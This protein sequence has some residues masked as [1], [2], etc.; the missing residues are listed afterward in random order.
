MANNFTQLKDGSGAIT[1]PMLNERMRSKMFTPGYQG[2]PRYRCFGRVA[3]NTVGTSSGAILFV[4]NIQSI[5]AVDKGAYII[6]TNNRNSTFEMLVTQL[7]PVYGTPPVFGYWDGGDGYWY[8]GVCQQYQA[9]LISV[10]VLSELNPA[11]LME[12]AD[13]TEFYESGSAP[14]GWTEAIQTFSVG[15]FAVASQ[16]YTTANVGTGGVGW[17]RV[18]SIKQANVGANA[19]QRIHPVGMIYLTGFYSSYK[20]SKGVFSFAYDGGTALGNIVQLAGVLSTSPTQIRMT[21]NSSGHAK[22]QGY[23]NIDLYYAN[24]ASALNGQEIAIEA[25]G[26]RWI[27]MQ[28][29]A[30][31]AAA[32]ANEVVR[33]TLSI[34]TI[35]T[36]RV[37]TTNT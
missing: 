8:I 37:T 25:S 20:P 22:G 28:A 15:D 10:T 29:P 35:A 1:F 12:L 14:S 32:P 27:E 6:Q 21:E 9:S 33:A 16:R 4:S 2:N 3:K 34:G 17:Y 24:S 18:A 31:V 23:I 13:G 19:G 7:A 11:Q 30:L 26:V 36:G 5:A